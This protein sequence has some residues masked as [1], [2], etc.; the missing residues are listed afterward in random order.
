MLFFQFLLIIGVAVAG[1]LAV[2]FLPGDRSLAIKR[3]LALLFVAAAV[4]A[5]IFPDTLTVVANFFGIGR[6]VDLLLYVFIVAALLFAAATVRAK[7]RT[8]A[9]VTELARAVALME[10][11]LAQPSEPQ[12]IEPEKTD[13]HQTDG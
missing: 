9:R 8:D 1:I 7:A 6:G 11:R 13:P 5:I 12:P 10:A 3:I 2:R 4:L